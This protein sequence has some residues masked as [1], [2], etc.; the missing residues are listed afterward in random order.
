VYWDEAQLGA[1]GLANISVRRP[2]GTNMQQ[3][4]LQI[5]AK[6]RGVRVLHG[7]N[8]RRWLL[9]FVVGILPLGALVVTQPAIAATQ[10]AVQLVLAVDVSGS[11]DQGRFELQRQGYAEAFRSSVV[12]QAIRST[13]TGSVAVVLLQWTGPSLHVVAVDWSFISD[14]ASA[15]RFA[16]A[17]EH[18]PRALFGGGTSISGAIDY[19]MTLFP[20]S[21]FQGVRRVID[22]SG[23][24][25]NNRGR[26]A[27]DAR[28]EAVQAGV[29]INGLP[30]LTLEPELGEYYRDSV[31]GGSGAF[32][33]AVRSYEEFAQAIRRKLVVEIAASE[34]QPHAGDPARS[35]VRAVGRH[36]G[37]N[38]DN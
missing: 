6:Y 14:A 31:I 3:R 11:V 2:V 7:N 38:S 27:E 35:L 20:R 10:V 13:V 37:G 32:V 12:Q 8:I 23:D 16:A 22:V 36:Q 33:I 19:A 30:I 4:Y 18:A 15:E 17:I 28:D 25:A 1:H 26:F 24:G 5:L 34:T 9:L 21:P 29:V